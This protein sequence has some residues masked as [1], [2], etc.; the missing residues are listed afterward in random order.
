M[1]QAVPGGI[2]TVC[3]AALTRAPF[4]HQAIFVSQGKDVQASI[5]NFE[6][7]KVNHPYYQ[8]FHSRKDL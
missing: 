3:G 1:R 5:L 6:S 4:V 8:M 2:G 7:E